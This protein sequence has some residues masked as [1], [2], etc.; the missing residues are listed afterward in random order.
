M[1]WSWIL[2]IGEK[3]L[4]GALGGLVALYFTRQRFLSERW[5]DKKY[6]VYL[7]TFET[8]R[9]LERSLTILGSS[10]YEGKIPEIN[11][12]FTIAAQEYETAL[13][14]LVSLQYKHILLTPTLTK[15]RIMILYAALRAFDPEM[16]SNARELN[17]KNR[18]EIFEL[19]KQSKRYVSGALGET[20]FEARKD[21][22]I[23]RKLLFNKKP[24]GLILGMSIN[25]LKKEAKKYEK[26]LNKNNT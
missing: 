15:D 9:R 17:E 16:I 8:L 6:H 13:S 11:D 23:E 2:N 21:L 14:N 10:I 20:T 19:A 12:E 3:I 7:E 25:D 24:E 26:K 5:W 18:K 22:G 1:E 4:L